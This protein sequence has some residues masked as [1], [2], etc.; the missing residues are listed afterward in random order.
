M[1]R[2]VWFVYFWMRA[3]AVL[4]E[5]SILEILDTCFSSL[6][7]WSWASPQDTNISFI[8]SWLSS[9]TSILVCSASLAS[10]S[11]K[12][13]ILWTAVARVSSWLV[14]TRLAP[15]MNTLNPFTLEKRV[16]MWGNSPTSAA[17]SSLLLVISWLSNVRPHSEKSWADT[18]EKIQRREIIWSNCIFAGQLIT[19]ENALSLVARHP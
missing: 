2:L 11:V 16:H 14:A 18:T 3:A 10:S 1:S 15:P 6:L 7:L 19:V 8:T 13:L 4:S 5:K 9:H 17:F 12:F